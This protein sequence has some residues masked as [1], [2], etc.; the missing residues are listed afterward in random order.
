[1]I[2]DILQV[3]ASRDC[4]LRTFFRRVLEGEGGE[5]LVLFSGIRSTTIALGYP[6]VGVQHRLLKKIGHR[7]AGVY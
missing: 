2:G 3:P 7:R 1:L 4:R 6:F 5:V